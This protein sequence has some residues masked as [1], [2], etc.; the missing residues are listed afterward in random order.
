MTDR[1]V[2]L[3]VAE[4]VKT[5]AAYLDIDHVR[6]QR[7]HRHRRLGLVIAIQCRP[8]LHNDRLHYDFIFNFNNRQ[9]PS[10]TNRRQHSVL[11]PRRARG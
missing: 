5:L 10:S 11:A 2:A 9:E 4:N 1:Q 6:L 7:E 3:Q 8:L